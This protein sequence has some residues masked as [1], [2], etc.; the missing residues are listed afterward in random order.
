[1]LRFSNM[2]QDSLFSVFL[3]M[4]FSP[5]PK[6]QAELTSPVLCS[7]NFSKALLKIRSQFGWRQ[8]QSCSL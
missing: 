8:T 3:S 1:M 7:A 6:D 2:F 4:S 5:S